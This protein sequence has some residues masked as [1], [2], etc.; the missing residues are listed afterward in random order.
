[1][2]LAIGPCH[3]S[4]IPLQKFFF[5]L[6]QRRKTALLGSRVNETFPLREENSRSHDTG[7]WYNRMCNNQLVFSGRRIACTK[8]QWKFVPELELALSV[9]RRRARRPLSQL[10]NNQFFLVVQDEWMIFN[11]L[12][13][14]LAL[15]LTNSKHIIDSGQQWPVSCEREFS[16]LQR[17]VSVPLQPGSAVFLLCKRDFFP[18]A[19]EFRSHHTGQCKLPCI[20]FPLPF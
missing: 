17:K 2:T 8:Q 4:G 11:L 1:M 5:L 7:Q 15:A 6:L 16:S 9:N 10:R 18:F 12:K 3:V 13:Y 19:K 14:T 20:F